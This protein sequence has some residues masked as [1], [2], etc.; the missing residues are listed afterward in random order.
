MVR[1]EKKN[2]KNNFSG[3]KCV[4]NFIIKTKKK[5]IEPVI[6]EDIKFKV[7]TRTTTAH[8]NI[9]GYKQDINCVVKQ[10]Q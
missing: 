10:N 8:T 9:R 3:N 6:R 7:L 5:Q 2:F 4:S 1:K